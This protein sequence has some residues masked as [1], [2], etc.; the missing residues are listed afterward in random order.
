MGGNS[1]KIGLVVGIVVVLSFLGILVLRAG[2]PAAFIRQWSARPTPSVVPSLSA[3]PSS[4]VSMLPTPIASVAPRASRIPGATVTPPATVSDR[5]LILTAMNARRTTVAVSALSSGATLQ[6]IA[7]AH[8]D[9]MAAKQFFSHTD[10]NGVTFEQ[11]IQASGYKGTAFAENL[12][13]TSTQAVDIV[14]SWMGSDAHRLN[15][16]NSSYSAVGIGIARG[17][18]E[19]FSV[20]FVVAVFGDQKE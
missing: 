7:Q 10:P 9:N 1:Q 5:S 18:W 17:T 2:G 15:M 8:A 6:E 20:V 4:S 11:R 13:L 12:G 19:G 3:E 14:A 16:L